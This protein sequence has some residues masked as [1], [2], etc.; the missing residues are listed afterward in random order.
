M[1]SHFQILG[2]YN[3]Q[4]ATPTNE[5]ILRYLVPV[6]GP[7]TGPTLQFEILKTLACS[8]SALAQSS[9]YRQRRCGLVGAVVALF[10][11]GRHGVGFDI[12]TVNVKPNISLFA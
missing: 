3:S 7:N 5:G 10:E 9:R 8:H 11:E 2:F 6:R 12:S 1:L 4:T